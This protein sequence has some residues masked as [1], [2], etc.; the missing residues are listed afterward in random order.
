MSNA[1]QM[2][3]AFFA[4]VAIFK[5][6]ADTVVRKR[7]IDKGMVDDKIKFLYNGSAKAKAL[8]N[9]K[10]GIVLIGIGLA[11]LLSYIFPDF[12]SEGGAVGLIFI[13]AGI[14]FLIYYFLL[15]R[16]ARE[17]EKGSAD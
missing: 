4:I 1:L 17:E 14:G 10:W 5:I 15:S 12:I 16:I 3:V 7:L 11:A 13:F 8:A 9:L 2:A 6:I